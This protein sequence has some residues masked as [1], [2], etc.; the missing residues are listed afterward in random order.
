[1]ILILEFF[2][3]TDYIRYWL[4]SVHTYSSKGAPVI[5]VFSHAEDNGANPKK[6]HMWEV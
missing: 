3:Q 1:M 2:F 5:L 6:V 4:G